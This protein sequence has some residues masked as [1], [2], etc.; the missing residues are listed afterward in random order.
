[1]ELPDYVG[2]YVI[3]RKIARGGFAVVALAWDEELAADVAIKILD[4]RGEHDESLKQ[5]FVEEARLLRRIKSYS[6]VGVHDVGRLSDGR[7]YFVMDH[8]DLGTLTDRVAARSAAPG[9]PSGDVV[10][11]VD[12]LASGLSAIHRAGVIHRDIKPENILF[13]TVGPRAAPAA[14]VG[15]EDMTV[16]APAPPPAGRKSPDRVMIGDLGIASDLLGNTQTS[17]I[18]GGTPAY[19]APEQYEADGGVSPAADVYSATAVLW[20]AITGARPPDAVA[21]P[22]EITRLAEPWHDFFLRGMSTDPT[23]RFDDVET[24]NRAAHDAMARIAAEAPDPGETTAEGH[25]I[26]TPGS[27]CPYRGLSSFQPEDSDRFFGREE[28]VADLVKRVQSQKVLVVGGSSGSGKSSLV[29]AGLI[30]ALRNGAIPGSENWRIE[31]FTPGRDALSELYFRLRGDAQNVRVRLDEFVARPSVARQVLGDGGGEPLLLAIDQ[32]EELCTLNEGNVAEGF[33]D[34]L[35]AITDPADSNVH[36]VIAV[37]ADFYPNCAQ[38][39]WLAEAVSRN[40]VLVGPMTAGDLRRAIVEPARRGGFYVEQHL[41]DAIVSEAGSDAGVL[42]LISHALVETWMRR[43]GATLTYEGYRASGGMAGAIRQTADAVFDNDFNDEERHVAKRLMLSLVT[44]GEGGGDARRI[45]ARSEIEDDADAEIMDRVI[46]RLTEARLLTIDDKTIQITHEALLRSWPRLSRWIEDSRAD[47]RMRLRVVQMAEEWIE[48]GRDP[49][50]LL[51][52]ARLDYT[53]EWLENNADKAGAKEREFLAASTAARDAEQ[54]ERDR[55]R[56]HLRRLQIAA[57]SALGVLAAGATVASFVAFNQ[58]RQARENAEIADAATIEANDSFASA[59]G[60]AAAGYS[61]EDPLLALNLAAQSIARASAPRRTY[62]ARA[63]LIQSRITLAAGAPVPVGAPVPAGDALALAISP[64]AGFVVTG[65]RDGTV[66]VIDTTTRQQIGETLQAGTG[67]VQDIAFAPD[68]SAFA[69]VSDKGWLAIWPFADGFPEAP[70]RIGATKDVLWRLAFHPQKPVIAT[71][72]E[73]GKLRIWPQ[74]G[75]ISGEGHVLAQRSGDF[76]SVAFSPDGKVIVAGNGS[77]ELRAWHYPD[78]GRVFDPITTLH[79]SDIWGLSF[80]A[81]GSLLATVSSDGSS[82]LVDLGTD[83]DNGQVFPQE[84]MIGAVAFMP[85][86]PNLVGGATDGSLLIWDTQEGRLAGQSPHGHTR[87]IIDIALAPDRRNGVTLGADQ[88]LRFW[89]M[90]PRPGLSTRFAVTPGAKAKGL[91]LGGSSVAYADTE[92]AVSLAPL[93]GGSATVVH[94]HDQQVWAVALSPDGS[95]IASAD[96]SGRILISSTTSGGAQTSLPAVGEAVWSLD[97]SADGTR[98]LAAADSS[99]R[100]YDAASGEVVGSFTPPTGGVTRAALSPDGMHLAISTSLGKVYVWEIGQDAP[101]ETMNV[102]DNLVWSVSFSPDGTLL[103]AGDS[104]EVV[105]VW[106]VASAERIADFTGHARGA[107][108]VIFLGDNATLVASDRRGGLHFWDLTYERSIGKILPA[109]DAAIWRLAAHPDGQ[110][111][112]SS[113]DDGI[114]HVW[115]VLSTQ[116]ACELSDGALG[117]QRRAQ[118][119]GGAGAPDACAPDSSD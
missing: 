34:A 12:A 45:V 14:G 7:P 77:G 59:L 54:K 67:G 8:A 119:L 30:A 85:Q 53:L 73:D 17:L 112:A 117:P 55:R 28:M 58:S 115:D 1:M 98:I 99:A 9:L 33:I 76:T 86:G 21:V 107:T 92:G 46:K 94:Q 109:H 87:P 52:G 74:S 43:M 36:V 114:V 95:R 72:G 81:D 97:F 51:R 90:G 79:S 60:A 15:N 23:G 118:Y 20:Y 26:A 32:F 80:S 71:A 11:L 42:P 13:Q 106:S 10:Q 19:M 29:R 64:D 48:S 102:S 104:D 82:A 100:L 103:A 89:R 44:P 38:F 31:L 61:M 37:R 110:S 56:R 84:E 18:L 2:R 16:L 78:G 93:A 101:T 111:F 105:S 113:G 96:R 83:T 24:W 39:P 62:D 50:M 6:I 65:G 88:Q 41:V 47:L 49:E 68:G 91:A 57:V 22:E 116:R 69:A 75:E 5:R 66:R 35:A 63:A 27:D 70:R 25:P 40:Q 3:R 108:D 4:Y